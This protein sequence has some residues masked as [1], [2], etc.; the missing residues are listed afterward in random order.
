MR[1]AEKKFALGFY[2]WQKEDYWLASSMGERRRPPALEEAGVV[3][4]I[5]PQRRDVVLQPP[6][7]VAQRP[8]VV[9]APLRSSRHLGVGAQPLDVVV[10]QL[11]QVVF[12]RQYVGL[13][14]E[15]LAERVR[16]FGQDKVKDTAQGEYVHQAS[17]RSVAQHHLGSNPT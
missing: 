9:V 16:S 5:V 4:T 3:A 14:P 15:A 17:R 12:A 10:Q 2:D 6:G 1:E 13:P 7:A 8:G 11:G